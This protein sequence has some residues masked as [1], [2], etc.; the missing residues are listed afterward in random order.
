MA[1]GWHMVLG[2]MPLLALSAAQE[3]D[4]LMPRLAQITGDCACWHIRCLCT[5]HPAFYCAGN[6]WLHA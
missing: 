5:Y 4:E 1:T 6:D 2:S 3:A